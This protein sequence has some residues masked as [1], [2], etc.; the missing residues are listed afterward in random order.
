[1]LW[2]IGLKRLLL[3]A[4]RLMARDGDLSLDISTPFL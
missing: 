4:S 1:M 2:K 3:R